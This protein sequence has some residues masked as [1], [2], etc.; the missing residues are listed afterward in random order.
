VCSLFLGRGSF[1]ADMFEG[2]RECVV[3]YYRFVFSFCQSLTKSA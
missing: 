3:N 1:G 2:L